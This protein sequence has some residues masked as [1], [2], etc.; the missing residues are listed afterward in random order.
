[1]SLIQD[2]SLLIYEIGGSRYCGNIQ[3]EHK[4]NNI[5][6]VSEIIHGIYEMGFFL[7]KEYNS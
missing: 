1:M 4:S 7:D 6:S 2:S 5:R 3:R